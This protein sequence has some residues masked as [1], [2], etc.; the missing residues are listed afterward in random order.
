MT[1]MMMSDC[2][3]ER[4]KG[5]TVRIRCKDASTCTPAPVLATFALHNASSVALGTLASLSLDEHREYPVTLRDIE[6]FTT[7]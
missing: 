2:Q 6:R 3:D 5:S 7:L 1:V 4:I